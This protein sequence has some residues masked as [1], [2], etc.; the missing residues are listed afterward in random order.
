MHRIWHEEQKMQKFKPRIKNELAY[1]GS[2]LLVRLQNLTE[3][4]LLQLQNPHV[5]PPQKGNF[6]NITNVHSGEGK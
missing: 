5:A 3:M 2:L 6:R 4:V 1:V